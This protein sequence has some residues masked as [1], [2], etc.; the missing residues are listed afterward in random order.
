MLR[1]P[2]VLAALVAGCG[3]VPWEVSGPAPDPEAAEPTTPILSGGLP[4]WI[5]GGE[6]LVEIPED[7][8]PDGTLSGCAGILYPG[9]N[10]TTGD[11]PVVPWGETSS[12]E[13]IVE[14]VGAGDCVLPGSAEGIRVLACEVTEPHGYECGSQ[15]AQRY[16][17][18]RASWGAR[19]S[20]GD[21]SHIWLRFQAPTSSPLPGNALSPW[22]ARVE[23]LLRDPER[24]A[25]GGASRLVRAA[26]ADP[27]M[28]DVQRIAAGGA[29][30]TVP[31][32]IDFGTA[33]IGCG[34]VVRPLRVVNPSL[35]PVLVADVWVSHLCPGV[36]LEQAPEL[37]VTLAP[38]DSLDVGLGFEAR[39]TTP[40]ACFVTIVSDARTDPYHEIPVRAAGSF[41]PVHVQEYVQGGPLG[42]VLIVVDDSPSMAPWAPPAL[43]AITALEQALEGTDVRI[44]TTTTAAG[45]H[46]G[47]HVDPATVIKPA[48]P[49]LEQSLAAAWH[50]ASHPGADHPGLSPSPLRESASLDV[51]VMT[52]EDDASPI[53]LVWPLLLHG[54]KGTAAVELDRI[55][56]HALT[57]GA[58]CT[59]QPWTGHPWPALAAQTGGVEG[60][61]CSPHLGQLV[62]S[63][64]EQV[65]G[66]PQRFVPL[67]APVDDWALA[68]ITIDGAKCPDGWEYD[69]TH[70]AA[71]VAG[72]TCLPLP[73]ESV[74]IS[75]PVACPI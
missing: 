30:A 54:L 11:T 36:T 43:A 45:H 8:R 5:T 69:E 66:T 67:G 61:L 15:P 74:R 57:A 62:A 18:D 6:S 73:G 32:A 48:G 55:R 42:D 59:G 22:P 2:I 72:E 23:V 64:A 47:A 24:Q 19:L 26:G 46:G 52:D 37:P 38:G 9:H 16:E 33:R 50:A 44:M 25:R 75:Y 40:E 35:V 41:E 63:I 10:T 20:P 28:P 4:G 31:A 21:R 51:V 12:V 60:A 71:T 1:L 58:P 3:V 70:G 53:P 49:W 29:I 13:I 14:V 27:S 56:V 39:G 34:P 17:V 68:A 7:L 65:L